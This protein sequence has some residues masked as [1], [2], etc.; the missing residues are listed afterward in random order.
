MGEVVVRGRGVCVF[1]SFFLI[2]CFTSYFVFSIVVLPHNP[3][4]VY[5]HVLLRRK[6]RI[7]GLPPSLFE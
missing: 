4:V 5:Y 1:L 6:T 2:V 7:P 3:G